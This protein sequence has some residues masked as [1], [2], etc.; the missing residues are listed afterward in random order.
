MWK[1][2]LSLNTSSNYTVP[3]LHTKAQTTT[4]CEPVSRMELLL[5][6][7]LTTLS[8]EYCTDELV[9][10]NFTLGHVAQTMRRMYGFPRTDHYEIA[11]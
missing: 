3:E 2:I 10:K 5:R 4:C 7:F 6:M 11:C 9:L 8:E 1:R